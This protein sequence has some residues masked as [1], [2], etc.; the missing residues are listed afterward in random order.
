MDSK[1]T[2]RAG[3]CNANGTPK[4]LE[5]S[6]TSETTELLAFCDTS[7]V[8]NLSLFV[9]PAINQLTVQERQGTKNPPVSSE[10]PDLEDRPQIDTVC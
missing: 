6:S 1:A 10:T 3:L 7:H 5:E 2:L 8:D 4:L 9:T